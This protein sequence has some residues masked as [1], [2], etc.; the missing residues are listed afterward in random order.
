MPN[1]QS[2]KFE[3]TVWANN[4]LLFDIESKGVYHCVLT[5][6]S[7]K[8]RAFEAS[9]A[10]KTLEITLLRSFLY[11]MDIGWSRSIAN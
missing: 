9:A 11:R 6:L 8:V 10:Q 5:V 3:K 2:S 7:A 1:V 4:S